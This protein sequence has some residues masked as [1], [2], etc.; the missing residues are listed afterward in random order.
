MTLDDLRADASRVFANLDECW[1]D[2]AAINYAAAA[3]V[4]IHG[5]DRETAIVAAEQARWNGWP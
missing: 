4:R 5:I 1:S 2:A 3:L